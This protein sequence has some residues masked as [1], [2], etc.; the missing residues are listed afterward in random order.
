MTQFLKE[1]RHFPITGAGAP[2]IMFTNHFVNFL[3]TGH[4][5]RGYGQTQQLPKCPDCC[6]EHAQGPQG[7]FLSL[8][9]SQVCPFRSTIPLGAPAPS[10][11]TVLC[12]LVPCTSHLGTGVNRSLPHCHHQG[13]HQGFPFPLCVCNTGALRLRECLT[14]GSFKFTAGR[15]RGGNHH[16]PSQ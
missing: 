15:Q 9:F 4:C 10:T 8:P 3:E 12:L 7:S 16:F 6:S 13:W 14:Q 11:G 1:H 2:H 5:A